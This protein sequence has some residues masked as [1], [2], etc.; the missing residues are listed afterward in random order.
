M[1]DEIRKFSTARNQYETLSFDE[2]ID[3]SGHTYADKISSNTFEDEMDAEEKRKLYE[4][5]FI[6]YCRAFT[7]ATAYPPR[8][9]ALY[10]ARVLPHLLAVIPDNK[11]SSA[12]WAFD[13]IT[14]RTLYYLK[15]DSERYLQT[16]VSKQ[17]TW[18]VPFL[19]QLDS[20]DESVDNSKRLG[21]I[22]YTQHFNKGKIEDWA[23]YMHKVCAKVAMKL[24][25]E[26]SVL[27]ET[28]KSYLSENEVLYKFVKGGPS[29]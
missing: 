24:V 5:L 22:I 7:E 25:M 13:Y 17:L 28:V 21:D 1:L 12:K 27:L 11:S 26:N 6:L 16:N 20:I 4:N 23:E 10:Y 8:S 2:P 19:D 29:R 3:D 14:D 18:C 9:L 15:D